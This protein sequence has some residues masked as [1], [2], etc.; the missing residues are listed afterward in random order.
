MIS[1]K[2][3]SRTCR[4]HRVG[5]LHWF[6]NN[7]P[8]EQFSDEQCTCVCGGLQ[9]SLPSAHICVIVWC[10]MQLEVSKMLPREV[11]EWHFS[12]FKYLG[13][14]QAKCW[15]QVTQEDDGSSFRGLSVAAV[16]HVLPTQ[17]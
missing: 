15:P 4:N 10:L 2:M 14:R 9:Q 6:S 12:N 8:N 5:E 17:C 16:S 3:F 13:L 7:A 1:Y 11:D